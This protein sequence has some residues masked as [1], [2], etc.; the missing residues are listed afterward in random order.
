MQLSRFILQ[1]TQTSVAVSH[2]VIWN[3]GYRV[4]KKIHCLTIALS[5]SR[6]DCL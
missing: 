2:W 3:D 1:P 4:S 5:R 6:L